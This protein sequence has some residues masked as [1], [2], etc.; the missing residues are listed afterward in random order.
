MLF[1]TLDIVAFVKTDK[2]IRAVSE[3]Y[4]KNHLLGGLGQTQ[5][6]NNKTDF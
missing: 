3:I 5:M 4:F 2:V 1:V 6:H